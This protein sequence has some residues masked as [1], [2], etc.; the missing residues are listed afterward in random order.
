MT[1]TDERV[2]LRPATFDDIPLLAQWDLDPD[3]IG[4]TTSEEGAT[5]AFGGIDWHEELTA[6]SPVSYHLIAEVNG[7][8]IGAMQICDPHEEPTHYWGEVAPNLRAVDIWIG[9]P[10]D[11][12]RGYGTDMMRLAHEVCFAQ[13]TV[14][15]IVIDPLVTNTRAIHFYEQL[16]YR[17]VHERA[18]EDD[19]CLVMRL[20]REQYRQDGAGRQRRP[21]TFCEIV[22]GRVPST[23]VAESAH[24]IAIVDLRQAHAG[25][26][27]VMPREHLHD[28]RDADDATI[29]DVMQLTARVS[30]AVSAAMPNDGISIWHSIGAGAHQEVPH[31]HVHI[32]PRTLDD[33]LLQVYGSPPP[34]P[35]RER[36]NA[37]GARIRA[38]LDQ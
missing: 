4:A 17:R 30:R 15:A 16:G 36:L 33:D 35:S 20:T 26:V 14:E 12:G 13:P 11:R 23:H 24:A 18:F 22:A 2:S 38:L 25:H 10:V 32:H 29:A 1:A 3:V 19:L 5:I 6:D 9:D 37:I 21:C 31:L 28:L 27:L 34:T 7:R 8:P